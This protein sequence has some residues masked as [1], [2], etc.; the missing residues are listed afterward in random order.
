MPTHTIGEAAGWMLDAQGYEPVNP[1]EVQAANRWVRFSSEDCARLYREHLKGQAMEEVQAMM[2]GNLKLHSQPVSE[3]TSFAASILR[4]SSYLL[5][6]PANKLLA[7]FPPSTWEWKT[8]DN[9]TLSMSLAVIRTSF[10]RQYNQ[11]I[12]KDVPAS[13]FVT[14]LESPAGDGGVARAGVLP[15]AGEQLARSALVRPRPGRAGG[16]ERTLPA[17]P[18]HPG[19]HR[20]AG[21]DQADA[22][23]LVQ[24]G[25]DVP[26]MDGWR[27]EPR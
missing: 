22:V 8:S 23:Q 25:D 20:Q 2:K 7:D 5:D 18:N 26:V 15:H 3:Q 16:P 4:L 1:G 6:T 13:G 24:P 12:P 14:G 9:G 17:W 19:L 11:L 27:G 10:P 21:G